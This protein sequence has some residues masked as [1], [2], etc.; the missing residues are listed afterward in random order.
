MKKKLSCILDEFNQGNIPNKK[1]VKNPVNQK[2]NNAP[3]LHRNTELLRKIDD[4]L[5]QG[6]TSKKLFAM[7]LEERAE[8]LNTLHWRHRDDITRLI[9][10]LQIK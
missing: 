1:A 8:Y 10:S 5:F 4:L 3:H 2:G 9:E 7:S 6:M